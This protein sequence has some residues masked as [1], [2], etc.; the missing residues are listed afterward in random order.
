MLTEQDLMR[1]R[2]KVRHQQLGTGDPRVV[3][4][5]D[6][7]FDALF[8]ALLE[9][10]PT[11][12]EWFAVLDFI[13]NAGPIQ[14]KGMAWLLGVTQIIEEINSPFKP[15]ATDQCVEGP[16]YR[17]GAPDRKS[18][19]PLFLVED[20]GDYIFF[21]GRVTDTNGKPL[22]GVVLDVWGTNGKG[23]YSQFDPE[24]PDFNCRGRVHAGPDG[25]Y[26]IFTKCPQPYT[27]AFEAMG[28]LL[29]AMGH[30]PWRPAH[31]H[32][33]IEHPGYEPLITQICFK[34]QPYIDN[35][36]ALA[37]KDHLAVEFTRHDRPEELKAR[38][39]KRPFYT[40]E[41]NFRLQPL[42]G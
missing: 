29:E 31:L 3:K 16:F 34:G 26:S 32:F 6:R 42:A 8:P 20:E 40:A 10:K 35:D 24:Q 2:E 11:L 19:E 25:N 41:F 9:V 1:W 7:V 18:G 17:P 38:G 22:P 15:E 36:S 14:L 30:Q 23:R 5:V 4:V 27:V 39:V 21:N 13:G 33:K 37:V 12:E 28:T